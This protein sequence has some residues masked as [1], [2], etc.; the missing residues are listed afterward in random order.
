MR[1][2]RF[3]FLLTCDTGPTHLS[4]NVDYWPSR[5]S[6]SKNLDLI[7][8]TFFLLPWVRVSS[9]VEIG[10]SMVTVSESVTGLSKFFCSFFSIITEKWFYIVVCVE[11]L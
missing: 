10:E 11:A 2:T 4:Q 5:R 6:R 9:L 8:K 1:V 7:K 3:D